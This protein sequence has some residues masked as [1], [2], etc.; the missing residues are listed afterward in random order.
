MSL[1]PTPPGGNFPKAALTAAAALVGMVV[2]LVGVLA[3]T[4][5]LDDRATPLVVSLLGMVATIVPGLVAATYSERASRDIRN[6]TVVEKAR[7]GAVR[8]LHD[9]Q[10]Q[11]V[12]R[13][14]AGEALEDKQVVTRVGPVVTAELA[15]LTQLLGETR[16]LRQHLEAPEPP[17]PPQT[18]GSHRAP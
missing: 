7:E 15:A 11:A 5:S 9:P 16:S 17:S 8:A 14:A 1:L 4:D 12:I 3:F 13:H 10:A 2:V 18:G 6:G